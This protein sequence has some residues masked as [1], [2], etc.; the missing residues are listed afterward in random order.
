MQV[1]ASLCRVVMSAKSH[2]MFRL[3]ADSSSDRTDHFSSRFVTAKA[4]G[5]ALEAL[6]GSKGSS[7]VRNSLDSLDVGPLIPKTDLSEKNHGVGGR[8]ITF[9]QLPTP[10]PEP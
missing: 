1:L 10:N 7:Y 3:G 2:R 4:L 8:G 5:M 9:K 6:E